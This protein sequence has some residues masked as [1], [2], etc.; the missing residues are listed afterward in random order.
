M[1]NFAIVKDSEVIDGVVAESI[2]LASFAAV[3]NT[4]VIEETET[5]GKIFIGGT[6]DAD[7]NIFIPRKPFNG[8]VFNKST[9]EWDPPKPMPVPGQWAWD[10]SLEDWV[11]DTPSS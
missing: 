10:E 6:Y 8:W 9:A 3:E 4:L 5:T 1:A 11:E 2:E 7:D